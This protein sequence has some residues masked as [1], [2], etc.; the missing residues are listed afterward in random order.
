[1]NTKRTFAD[2]D[3][4]IETTN[5][6]I[7]VGLIIVL[8]IYIVAIWANPGM[9]VK[10]VWMQVALTV[11]FAL[12]LLLNLLFSHT[13]ILSVRATAGFISV[14][15]ILTYI[16]CD[17]FSTNIFI[18]Y[19]VY[20]PIFAFVLYYN[21]KYIRITAT[22]AFV[23]GVATK[24]FDV[25]KVNREEVFTYVSAMIFVLAFTLTAYVISILFD[26]YNRDIFGLLEDE[27]KEQEGAKQSLDGVLQSVRSEAESINLQLD[28]LEHASDLIADNIK[29]VSIGCESTNEA[30]A[31]QQRMADDIGKL[32]DTTVGKGKEITLISKAVNEAVSVGQNS[33]ENLSELSEGIH[34]TNQEVIETMKKLIK[35]AEEM[36]EV[37][38]TIMAISD[39]TNLLALNASI[40]A[41]RAG[42][43]G[44]G[45]AV[46]ASEIG[47]LSNQSKEATDSIRNIIE[48]FCRD[49][50]EAGDVVNH[51]VESAEHQS[52]YIEEMNSQFEN[53]N[54]KMRELLEE[55]GEINKALK[56]VAVTNEA[57]KDSARK[58]STVADNVA[59]NSNDVLLEAEKNKARTVEAN[60]SIDNVVS[61]CENI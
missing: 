6:Y 8:A 21:K 58:L 1:M 26:Q 9:F 50:K 49:A 61:T 17:V 46:V 20:G 44:R 51:S 37:V 3:K 15:V 43:S 55:V 2:L 30:A 52:S 38:D 14:M 23:F 16:L 29:N 27:K 56:N 59:K 35:R 22:V 45:F 4:R 33:A 54:G 24:I 19:L 28:E 39:Q 60:K 25:M 5:R 10:G 47:N 41:A 57:V 13:N 31:E 36:Q 34:A 53:I 18:P 7:S 32:I 42:E 48:K 40:E 12:N 11:V